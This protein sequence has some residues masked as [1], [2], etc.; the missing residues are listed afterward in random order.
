[1]KFTITF[2]DPDGVYDS[3]RNAASCSADDIDGISDEERDK[4][5]ELREEKMTEFIKRW[6]ECEE[7][8]RVE[9]DTEASTAMV[10]EV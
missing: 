5:R 1:M 7:Y 3:I 10:R 8:V 4:I 2:K 9:F 6:V